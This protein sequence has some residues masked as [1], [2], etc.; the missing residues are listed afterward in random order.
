MQGWTNEENDEITHTHTQ[1]QQK[2]KMKRKTKQKIKMKNESTKNNNKPG[3]KTI[4][5]SVARW[6]QQEKTSLSKSHLQL[7]P[8][9]IPLNL[10]T[11]SNNHTVSCK[12]SGST[13]NFLFQSVASYTQRLATLPP[14]GITRME[15]TPTTLSVSGEWKTQ[16]APTLPS[17]SL[18]MTW[19]QSP[20]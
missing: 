6:L 12:Q 2:T 4:E 17:L 19:R 10:P 3:K 13:F 1:E 5:I 8:N 7:S 20:I 18:L 16:R 15:T 9:L 14:L 11:N